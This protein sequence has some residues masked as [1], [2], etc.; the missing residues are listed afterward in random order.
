MLLV[1]SRNGPESDMQQSLEL[2]A[3]AAATGLVVVFWLREADT[4]CVRRKIHNRLKL[5]IMPVGHSS[6]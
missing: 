3:L 6:S 1:A 5:W 4:V 2:E